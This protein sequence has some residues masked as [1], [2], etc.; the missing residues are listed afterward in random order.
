[1]QRREFHKLSIAA[2]SG[3][4]AGTLVGC[5]GETPTPAPAAKPADG[6][7][8]KDGTPVAAE[9]HLCSGLNACKNK[10]I[11]GKNDCAG[12]GDCASKVT[13][14]TCGME[15]ACKGQGGCGNNPG[16]NECAKK[17]GCSVP[18]MGSAWKK[19]RTRFEEK[20]KQEK[21]PFGAG[22]PP[23]ST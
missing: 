3:A 4:V 17:G 23:K 15:N 19:L 22:T 10:G 16:E 14:H 9:W 20:M 2:L 8:T 18:L 11:S 12:Q 7:A 21:K 6:S 1:M 13:H 5:G